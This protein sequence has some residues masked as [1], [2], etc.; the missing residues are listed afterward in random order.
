MAA[1]VPGFDHDLF[2]SYSHNDSSEWIRA[3][4]ESLRQQLGERLGAPVHIWQDQNNIRFGQKWTDEIHNGIC[5]SAGFLAVLSPSYRNSDW[6]AQE[7]QIFLDHCKA[8]NQLRAGSFYRFL[9]LVK[10]PWPEKGHEKFH[11]ELHHIDFFERRPGAG[12]E[13]E[14]VELVPGTNE[15]RARVGKAAGAIAALLEAMRRNREAV[16]IA[17]TTNDCSKARA[18]LRDQLRASGYDVRPDGPI[19]EGFDDDLIK[20]DIEPAILSAHL[21]GG[22]YDPFVDHQIDLAMDLEKRLVFWLTREAEMTQD[23]KQRDLI[24]AIRL[25]KRQRGQWSLLNNL[26]Q[27]AVIQDLLGMLRPQPAAT[28]VPANGDAAHVY[29]LCDPTTPED[30]DFARQLQADI[31]KAEGMHVELPLA[32]SPSVSARSDLHQKL[33]R[34]SDGLLLYRKAA[35]ERWLYHTFQDVVYAE[36]LYQR[37]QLRSKG[38]LLNDASVLPAPSG[39]PVFLQSPQFSLKDIEP[40]LAPLR[41]RGA[42]A[43][44]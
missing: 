43:T 27:R 37:P 23:P 31:R 18:G 28:G 8:G 36:R 11:Q 29:L 32:D 30:A 16:F 7:R 19:D 38:F 14:E 40:F 9:K 5:S 6:C 15:F 24:E 22:V 42:H 2:L 41:E 10:L 21:L 33:L 35:P 44:G 17:S 25:G 39:V 1:Y 12:A 34:E 13:V 3:L 4:E 20:G 26:S